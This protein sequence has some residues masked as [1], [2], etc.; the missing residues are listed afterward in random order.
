MRKVL[1]VL[2]LSFMATTLY[3]HVDGEMDAKGGH[4]YYRLG[5]YHQHHDFEG[6]SVDGTYNWDY[7]EFARYSNYKM[8]FYRLGVRTYQFDNG[9]RAFGIQCGRQ[10]DSKFKYGNQWSVGVNYRKRYS[11]KTTFTYSIDYYRANQFNIV[12]YTILYG[13]YAPK[14]LK[15]WSLHTGFILSTANDWQS[16]MVSW[17]NIVEYDM[18]IAIMSFRYDYFGVLSIFSTGLTYKF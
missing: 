3:A 6:S 13:M 10:G 2:F 5:V 4:Y 7:E 8:R 9:K 14:S 16:N 17:T 11:D 15:K 12:D 1:L 18:K